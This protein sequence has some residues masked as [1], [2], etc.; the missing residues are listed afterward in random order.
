MNIFTAQDMYLT[1][2]THIFLWNSYISDKDIDTGQ[3]QLL[4]CEAIHYHSYQFV[5]NL[6]TSINHIHDI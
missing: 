6:C 5:L 1:A 4:H 2:Y 3:R